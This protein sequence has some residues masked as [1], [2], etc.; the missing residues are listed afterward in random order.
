MKKTGIVLIVIGLLF[1]IVT[2]FGFF[3]KKKIVDIGK[4]QITTS[5]PH[6]VDWSPY[7]G[8]GIMIVGGAFIL[9][10]S[11]KPG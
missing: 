11:K 6:R 10:G 8:V 7:V 9:I 4:L 2:G 5:E 1:T 3:T